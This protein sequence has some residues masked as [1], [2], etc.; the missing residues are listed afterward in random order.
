MPPPGDLP[1]TGI[2]P[3]SPALQ[4]DSLPPE[5]LEK[6]RETREHL[7]K[8]RAM[9][10]SL[11]GRLNIIKMAILPKLLIDTIQPESNSQAEFYEKLTS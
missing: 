5:S 6:P 11:T 10:C 2:E 3:R 9:L 7:N 1:N 8:L 4:A